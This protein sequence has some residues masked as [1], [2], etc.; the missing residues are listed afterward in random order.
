VTAIDSV[1]GDLADLKPEWVVM[2]RGARERMAHRGSDWV[3]HS[4][5]SYRQLVKNVLHTAALT[6]VVGK[7]VRNGKIR[8]QR[9]RQ[10]LEAAGATDAHRQLVA[11]QCQQVNDQTTAD[12][13]LALV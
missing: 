13:G 5:A 11:D 6:P 1:E 8:A 9:S 7:G 10:S 12:G 3:R 2:L 4:A